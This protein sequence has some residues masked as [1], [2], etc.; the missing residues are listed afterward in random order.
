MLFFEVYFVL[1]CLEMMIL[2]L[3]L[4]TIILLMEKCFQSTFTTLFIL[5]SSR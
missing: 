5:W 1:N 3:S 2:R 4:C